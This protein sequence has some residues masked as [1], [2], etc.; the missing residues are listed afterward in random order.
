MIFT[1]FNIAFINQANIKAQ[2]PEYISPALKTVQF[3]RNDWVLSYPI[4][5]L[6][7]DQTL[8]L[9]F[10]EPGS[11]IKNYY[12]KITLC[13]ADWQA[14]ALMTTEYITGIP[15]NPITDY[16]F[17]FN[18]TFDYIHYRLTIPNSNINVTR[19]GNY[20]LTV[21]ENGHEATPVLIKRFMV[22]ETVVTVL[23][24]TLNTAQSSIRKAYQE[25]DFKVEH[26]GFNINNPMDEIS[27][28]II[29]NGRTDN[30]IH[31]LKPLF[32]R[33][34]ELDFNYNR[35]VI[36]EGG[37]EFR[38]ADLRSTRFVTDQVASIDFVDPFYHFTLF[39]DLPRQPDSYHYQQDINGKYLIEVTEYDDDELQADY[40]F[41]HFSLK[42][43]RP[44]PAQKIYLNGALTNW[45]L[46]ENS[47]MTYNAQQNVYEKTLVLKQGY[48]NYQ[49][50]VQEDDNS[51]GELFPIENSFQETEN[52]YLILI[53]YKSMNDRCDRLIGTQS[54]N[55]L[56]RENAQ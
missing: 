21:Y 13:D 22:T 15:S 37:N 6:N 52:D 24:S 54:I 11:G 28:T 38:Y 20:L 26:K 16:D 36:M 34:E 8:T 45:Q 19:S 51:K 3:H 27:A 44:Q 33:K 4:F 50:L 12:Y 32:V 5:K 7:S 14:S 17:S 29:Q 55:T 42:I 35:E 9:S 18:T 10:D 23:S 48:Y 53:Y 49:Y 30:I 31:G 43:A 41:V 2:I 1:I 46:N 47:L 39:T 40:A 56:R 25:I